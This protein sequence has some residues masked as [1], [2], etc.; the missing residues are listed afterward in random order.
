MRRDIDIFRFTGAGT[1]VNLCRRNWNYI[2]EKFGTFRILSF[3]STSRTIEN[4]EKTDRKPNR[5]QRSQ[6]ESSIPI[7]QQSELTSRV[8]LLL[9]KETFIQIL[10]CVWFHRIEWDHLLPKYH[11]EL[12]FWF[13]CE[14]RRNLVFTLNASG[15]FFW[16]L[17]RF[18]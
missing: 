11:I 17:L 18:I 13:V 6:G 8:S 2:S 14:F 7:G 16:S 15:L 10:R 5:H 9:F 12:R 3:R 1:D 4:S